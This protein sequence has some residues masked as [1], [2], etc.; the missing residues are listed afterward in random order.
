L[1]LGHGDDALVNQLCSTK[2]FANVTQVRVHLEANISE[3]LITA[4]FA[5]MLNALRTGS[6]SPEIVQ[7][8]NALSRELQG[9]RL[10]TTFMSVDHHF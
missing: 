8:F 3:E 4:E 6:V 10:A 1:K 7:Q 9:D 2:F 5:R